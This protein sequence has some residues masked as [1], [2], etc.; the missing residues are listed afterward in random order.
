MTLVVK[1]C[2]EDGLEKVKKSEGNQLE[3]N[4]QKRNESLNSEDNDQ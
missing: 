4:G 2:M 1:S 3:D